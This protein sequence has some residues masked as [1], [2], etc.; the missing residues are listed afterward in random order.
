[1]DPGYQ[2]N[3][4]AKTILS[5]LIAALVILAVPLLKGGA[6]ALY[7]LLA[8]VLT[9]TGV[10]FHCL[11]IRIEGGFLHW[12]FGPGFWKKSVALKDIDHVDMVLNRWYYG[13]GIRYTRHG[14][15][16]NVSGLRA[17]QITLKTGKK[18]RLGTDEPEKLVLAV[19]SARFAMKG[20]NR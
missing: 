12:H 8:V 19:N 11:T 9:A 14:W 1:M 3:Q 18:L 10:L 20:D 17:V 6:V 16:Y 4:L 5:F 13:W 15:L 2:H 7:A